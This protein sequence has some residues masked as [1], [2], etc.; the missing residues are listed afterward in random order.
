MLS[1]LRQVDFEPL[2]DSQVGGLLGDARVLDLGEAGSF[3]LYAAI[4]ALAVIFVCA[5]VPESRGQPLEG[6]DEVACEE[7]SRAAGGPL[8]EGARC[9]DGAQRAPREA[10]CAAPG[11]EV[12]GGDERT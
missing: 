11:A 4:N 8:A 3:A 1:F 7:G 5:C 6:T 9:D 10:P 12:A 2:A